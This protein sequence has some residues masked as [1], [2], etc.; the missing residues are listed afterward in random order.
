MSLV[1]KLHTKRAIHWPSRAS[2]RWGSS[3]QSPHRPHGHSSHAKP[4]NFTGEYGIPTPRVRKRAESQTSRML[5]TPSGRNSDRLS[6][7]ELAERRTRSMNAADASNANSGRGGGAANEADRTPCDRRSTRSAEGLGSLADITSL[8][9]A[10]NAD[11]SGGVGRGDGEASKS[12]SGDVG[13]KI[14]NGEARAA[15]EGAEGGTGEH[16][17]AGNGNGG[18]EGDSGGGGGGLCGAGGGGETQ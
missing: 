9:D 3:A 12:A 8:P 17:G 11:S 10:R 4:S 18:A 13:T 2:A 7:H 1:T 14:G 6:D 16:G 15:G 5:S